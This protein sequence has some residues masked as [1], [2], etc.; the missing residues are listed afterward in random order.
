MLGRAAVEESD[1]LPGDAGF[2]QTGKDPRDAVVVRIRVGVSGGIDREGDVESV[3]VRLARGRLDTNTGGNSGNHDLC[4]PQLLQVLVQTCVRECSPGPLGDC[5]V[6]G[7]L[8]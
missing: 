7:L 8:V 6:L 4:N 5:V 1:D 3:L 2:S